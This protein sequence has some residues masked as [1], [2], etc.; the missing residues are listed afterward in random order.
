MMVQGQHL[1]I[2]SL[3]RSIS[4]NRPRWQQY[5]SQHDSE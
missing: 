5:A 2:E 1:S 4:Y 3:S